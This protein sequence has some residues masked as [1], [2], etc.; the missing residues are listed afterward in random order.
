MRVI[1]GFYTAFSILSKL[2]MLN[3]DTGTLYATVAL[4]ENQPPQ[5]INSCDHELCRVYNFCLYV[6]ASK[7]HSTIKMYSC[8]K[9]SKKTTQ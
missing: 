6:Q 2:L 7:N 8:L 9:V 1:F 5:N 3:Q 4:E